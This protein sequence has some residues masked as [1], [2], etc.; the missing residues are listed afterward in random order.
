MITSIFKVH[1]CGEMTQAPSQQG[2]VLYKKPIRLQEFAGT[3]RSDTPDRL[4]NGIVA[5]MLGSLAQNTYSPGDLVVCSLRFSI[6]EYQGQWYQDI[7]V[8][9]IQRLQ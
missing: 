1:G 7:T 4:S 5:T 8:V 2:G 3:N 6:R 9:D